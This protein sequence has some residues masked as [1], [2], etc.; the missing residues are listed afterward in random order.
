MRLMLFLPMFNSVVIYDVWSPEP[1]VPAQ[2]LL[3]P[4]LTL[5]V[6]F[7]MGLLWGI[8]WGYIGIMEKKMEATI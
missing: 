5:P 1:S 2:E 8:Y 7:K 6:I 3:W 4:H